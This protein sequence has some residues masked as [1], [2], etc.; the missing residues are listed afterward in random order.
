MEVLV[1]FLFNTA[2]QLHEMFFQLKANEKADLYQ[3]KLNK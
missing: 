2:A 1:S 3:M